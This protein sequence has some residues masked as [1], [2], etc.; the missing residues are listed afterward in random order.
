MSTLSLSDVFFQ[1]L[2]M[3]KLVARALPRIQLGELTK[4][5]EVTILPQSLPIPFPSTPTASRL[6]GRQHKF[7]AAPMVTLMIVIMFVWNRQQHRPQMYI[8]IIAAGSR[9]M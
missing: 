6:S 1:A 4:L 2:N 9:P 7:L 5:L 8:Q 3:L